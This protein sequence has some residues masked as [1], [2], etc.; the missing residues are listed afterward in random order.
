MLSLSI[1]SP[2]SISSVPACL[3]S[4]YFASSSLT[5]ISCSTAAPNDLLDHQ[6]LISHRVPACKTTWW[7][8]MEYCS[9]CS[10]K[11]PVWN[12]STD[13]E[14]GNDPRERQGYRRIRSASFDAVCRPHRRHDMTWWECSESSDLRSF[15][16]APRW[17]IDFD[18]SPA[19]EI[20]DDRHTLVASDESTRFKQG[21]PSALEVLE[22]AP[23]LFLLVDS[24][25]AQ[26]PANAPNYRLKK[27]ILNLYR[28]SA[29]HSSLSASAASTSHTSSVRGR[30]TWR[31]ASNSSIWKTCPTTRSGPISWRMISSAPGR[32]G[33]LN[34]S[35]LS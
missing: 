26:H 35:Y 21:K 4:S 5:Q 20:L 15:G 7:E 29:C 6:G 8:L 33:T 31:T 28:H 32:R 9:R 18:S 25:Q 34:G 27:R 2:S 17:N 22:V 12:T 16:H 19:H 14:R 23:K 1:R 24:H 3:T 30:T 10:G 11:G 13:L